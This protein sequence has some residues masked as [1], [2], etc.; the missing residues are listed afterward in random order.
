MKTIFVPV[1]GTATDVGVFATAFTLGRSLPGA[2][3]EFCHLRL[4][5]CESALHDP[6]A[7]FVIGPAIGATLSHFEKRGKTLATEAARHVR[8][9]CE[10]HDIP[11]VD[12]PVTATGLSASCVE[13]LNYPEQRLLLHARHSDVTVLGRKHTLD[14]M[15]QDMIGQL[16]TQSGRPVVIAPDAPPPGP[17]QTVLIGWKETA[18]CARALTAAM[19]LLTAARR[20][21]L[22][23]VTKELD[24][25]RITLSHLARQLRWNGVAAEVITLAESSRSTAQQLADTAAA[26]RADLLVVG[27]YGHNAF[28]EHYFGGVTRDLLGAAR[29]PVL[30][31]H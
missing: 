31:M 1:S 6:H 25:S 20:V 27:G 19:P 26:E 13:E 3:M 24:R 18:E 14:L 16:L 17:I 11:V 22:V 30:L 28:R 15:P 29:L 4:D 7:H 21:I 23:T 12:E 9:F 10:T 2:H 8:D 5:P